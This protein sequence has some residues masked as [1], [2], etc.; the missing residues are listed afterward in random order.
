MC[1]ICG[2]V[3]FINEERA[4]GKHVEKMGSVLTHRG[5]DQ[6]GCFIDKGV[7]FGHNRLA[8]MDIEKGLQPMTRNYRGRNYT[9]VYNGEI[10]NTPELTKIIEAAGIKLQTRCD[11]EVVLYMYIL[12]KE[13]CATFLNGIFAFAVWDEEKEEV[14]LAR[15]RFGIKP[16]FYTRV[17]TT[18]LFA[19]EIKA[20]L[21]YEGVKP[22]LDQQG[23]WQMVYLAPT[24]VGGTSVF[25]NIF[26][27]PTGCY[28]IYK[29]DK[30]SIVKYWS[31][32]A[33]T[34]EDNEKEAVERTRE[35]LTDAIK[36]QL[37][38]DVPLA[39]FLSGG[40]DSTIITSVAAK[41][42]LEEGRKLGT[43]SF[44]YLGNK[45]NFQSTLF[46]PQSD[47]D[48][49]RYVANELGTDHH[50]LTA[51]IGSLINLLED[52]TLYRDLP[53]MADIDSSLLY[54][55]SQVKKEHT[56]VLSGECADEIFGGY[57]WF[58]RSEML[59]TGF[60]PWIH[61]ASRRAE[62]F[63]SEWVKP[64]EGLNYAKSIYETSIK[65]CP[66]LDTDS[67]SMRQSRIA[68]WL[69]VEYFM[70]SLLERKDRMSMASGVEV[71]VPFADHRILE[72]VYNIPWE[73]KFKNQVEKSL[74]REAM[75]DYLPEKVLNRKKSPY[76][77]TH[78]PQYEE[79]IIKL[80]QTR[81]GDTNSRLKELIN[82]SALEDLLHAQNVTWFGQLMS[83]PQLLAWLIQMDYW[84]RAYNVDIRL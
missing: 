2:I 47:D 71:R 14:Y 80:L 76:P 69:C 24:K 25:K 28:G 48:Y 26:E 9:I 51:D 11:T 4:L 82:P 44:E 50:I 79:K 8:I 55:C 36:R 5:P 75:K 33:K 84:L 65:A 6:K 73:I 63:R 59:E 23:L 22:I 61:D 43:Y 60:F 70:T 35:L 19:S 81:L 34:F 18:L 52:A 42:Y 67:K 40:L 13:E 62:L 12:K 72:Y 7:A 31:L 45:E 1:S 58:Y 39:T 66:I 78:N 53:G 20:L 21:T 10:Y 56:V 83:K 46:Q 41:Q 64:T 15:D 30:L 17:G 54:Y 38:S 77:K 57:P 29:K 3:D 37:V 27:I 49:A 74:L 16:L 68:T 32:T